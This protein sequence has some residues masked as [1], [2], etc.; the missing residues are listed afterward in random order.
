MGMP[1]P[2][3]RKKPIYAARIWLRVLWYEVL[4]RARQLK[5]K[6]SGKPPTSSR[7]QQILNHYEGPQFVDGE[8]G[9]TLTLGE[10]AERFGFSCEEVERVLRTHGLWH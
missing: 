8:Y 3:L 2:S 4:V 5:A 6:A 7:Q 1:L 10:F 9:E